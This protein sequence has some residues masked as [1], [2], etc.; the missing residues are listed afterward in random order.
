MAA[1]SGSMPVSRGVGAEVFRPGRIRYRMPAEGAPHARTWMQWPARADI[2]GGAA[3]LD[4]V[5]RDLARLARAIAPFEEVVLLVRPDQA[6]GAR[7]MC[8]PAVRRLA[9]PVDDLWARDCGPTFVIGGP[10]ELAV[11]DMNFNG[12]GGK[13]D[14][15]A[16]AKVARRIA[17]HCHIPWFDAGFVAEGGAL[18]VDGDGTLLATESA[19][20]NANRNPGRTKREIETK[21]KACLG[22]DKIVW[23]P[24]LQ[25]AD[26]TDAHIDAIARFV[27]PGL[28]LAEVPAKQD[29][30]AW[31]KLGHES[32]EILQNATDARGRRLEVVCLAQP[33]RLRSRSKDFVAS[34]VNYYLCN[35]AVIMAEFGDEGTDA[36][37]R[38]TLARLYPE[39]TVVQL[40]VDRICESGGGI[41]CVTQQQPA[42]PLR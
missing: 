15:D 3:R 16:D 6:E 30:S 36:Q 42:A 39:R 11:A 8:G 13:Q 14:H 38:E 37:A 17:E 33:R 34:Y 41:H 28:V 27:R 21:L 25:G 2:A 29:G 9:V 4:A 31:S 35:G 12:W 19:I 26:I 18:E 32:M 10:G 20:L 24:G 7:N 5:R 40:D 22:I 23:L 1:A